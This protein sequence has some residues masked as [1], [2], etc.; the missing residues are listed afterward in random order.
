MTI[1]DQIAYHT[2]LSRALKDTFV[3]ENEQTDLC[4][5]SPVRVLLG[6]GRVLC[7]YSMEPCVEFYLI[8]TSIF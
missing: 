6:Q 3:S 7:L 5:Y 1:Y 2:K 8:K 4:L